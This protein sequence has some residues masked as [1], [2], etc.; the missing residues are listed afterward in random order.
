[1]VT[2]SIQAPMEGRASR[3]TPTAKVTLPTMRTERVRESR[4]PRPRDSL[5]A[6]SMLMREVMP[7]KRT[8][9]KNKTEK[10]RPPGICWKTRGRVMN[11]RGGP[12]SGAMPKAKTAGRMA[13]PARRAAAVSSMAVMTDWWMMSSD[14]F[15]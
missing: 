12:L 10:K 6:S 7:A 4:A 1:M 3:K 14:F 13:K 9:T 15:I 2:A 5:T 8:E 11:M